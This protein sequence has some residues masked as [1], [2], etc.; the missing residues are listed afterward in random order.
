MSV[1]EMLASGVVLQGAIEVRAY[2]P[3]IDEYVTVFDELCDNGLMG[4]VD[5]PWADMAVGYVYSP[6]G[7]NGM[8]IEV[9]KEEA[10]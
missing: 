6:Y 5:E 8:V 7:M 3:D 10:C 4:H 2:D 1:N 9:A